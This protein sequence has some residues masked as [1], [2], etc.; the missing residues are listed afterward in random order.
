M[1]K[2]TINNRQAIYEFIVQFK[3][4]HDGNSPT[5]RE[6]MAAIGISSSST[7][8]Y[9]LNQLEEAGLIIRPMEGGNSRVIEIPGAVW[10]PPQANIME[11]NLICKGMKAC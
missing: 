9:Y 4:D 6:I 11:I 3:I 8:A 7:V 1:D 10:V 2:K 5:Y